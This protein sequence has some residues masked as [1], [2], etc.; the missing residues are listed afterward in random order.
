MVTEMLYKSTAGQQAILSAYDAALAR[1]WPAHETATVPTRYGDT[2]VVK[3]GQSGAPPLVLL[4]GAGSNSAVWAGDATVYAPHFRVY[5][6]DLIGEPGRSAPSRPPWDGPAFAEWL[7]DVVNGLQLERIA[8]VGMSQGGWAALKFAITRPDQVERLVLLAPGGVVRDRASFLMR[9][10]GN[11]IRGR[12]GIE[13]M[14]RLVLGD[15]VIPAELDD[16]LTLIMTEFKPRIGALPIFTDAELARLAM[17][18]LLIGGD[19]DVIRD[20]TAIAARL[21]ASLPDVQTVILPGVGHTLTETTIYT[22]PF[23]GIA[24]PA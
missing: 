10:I 8:L 11:S 9:A 15:T 21:A 17:P 13:S 12:R 6:V 16:Y 14:K 19:Q 24:Q 3:S 23:L 20:E 7:T 18:V 2:F 1:Y 22:L 5:A 4:H